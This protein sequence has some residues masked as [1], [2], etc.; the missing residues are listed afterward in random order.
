MSPQ[1]CAQGAV[2]FASGFEV[3]QGPTSSITS[4]AGRFR[5]LA[6]SVVTAWFDQGSAEP[7]RQTPDEAVLHRQVGGSVVMRAQLSKV[8]TWAAADKG[9]IQVIPF[10]AGA[11][12]S[13]D[14]NFDL[15]ELGKNAEQDPVVYVEGLVGALYHERPAE[16]TRYREAIEHLRES[17][18]STQES[19]EVSR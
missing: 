9:S 14:S 19:L 4:T 5:Q 17:A 6:I 16:I 11:H 13:A 3:R 10:T 1:E 7:A 2:E 18:L 15:L 12:A 8:L